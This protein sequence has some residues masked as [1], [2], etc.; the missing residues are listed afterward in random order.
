[1]LQLVNL[2]N[3]FLVHDITAD[4]VMGVGWINEDAA[5]YKDVDSLLNEPFLG[6]DWIDFNQ[7]AFTILLVGCLMHFGVSFYYASGP[8]VK[9][10]NKR[11]LNMTA[12]AI[13]MLIQTAGTQELRRKGHE[14]HNELRSK[15]YC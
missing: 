11:L 1:M 15:K 7:H 3:G 14:E 8:I 10:T 4:A 6:I 12:F 5:F 2:F 13:R 9:A